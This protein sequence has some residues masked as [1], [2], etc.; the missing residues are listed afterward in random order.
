MAENKVLENFQEALMQYRIEIIDEFLDPGKGDCVSKSPL[1][2]AEE[3]VI[4]LLPQEKG[5]HSS[6]RLA[7]Y[8]KLLPDFKS[9]GLDSAPELKLWLLNIAQDLIKKL[10]A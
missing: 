7:I 3:A 5:D 10:A 2:I 4:S 9:E 6:F 1:E 8:D